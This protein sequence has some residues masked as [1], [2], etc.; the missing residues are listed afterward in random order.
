MQPHVITINFNEEKPTPKPISVRNGTRI[1]FRIIL[2]PDLKLTPTITFCDTDPDACILTINDPTHDFVFTEEK[3]TY[4]HDFVPQIDKTKAPTSQD[5]FI[6]NYVVKLVET[7]PPEYP[8]RD[9]V[10]NRSS[11]GEPPTSSGKIEVSGGPGTELPS[12]V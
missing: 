2:P 6:R 10:E 8:L 7:V 9:R 5:R 1:T 4:E 12:L 11:K 3:N